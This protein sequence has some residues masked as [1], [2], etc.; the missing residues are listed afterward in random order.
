M[1]S[2]IC[3][4]KIIAFMPWK[5]RRRHVIS[6]VTKTFWKRVL[7]EWIRMMIHDIIND[8]I[9]DITKFVFE[10]FSG[11][12]CIIYGRKYPFTAPLMSRGKTKFATVKWYD[13]CLQIIQSQTC[14][15]VS[16][17]TKIPPKISITQRLRNLSCSFTAY[18]YPTSVAKPVCG[19]QP[20][21]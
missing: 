15:P 5:Q 21:H 20:S 7:S 1:T 12:Y 11:I 9:N 16:N 14:C 8:I 17:K 6:N 2:N 19:R 10:W 4:I 18:M 13:L 3:G